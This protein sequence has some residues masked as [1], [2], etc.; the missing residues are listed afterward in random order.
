MACAVDA[1]EERVTF[2]YKFIRGVCPKS[3]G[4]NVARLAGLPE[5]VVLRARQMSTQFE[6][7]L[8]LAHG[9]GGAASCA[10][11]TREALAARDR[12][13]GYAHEE[14][15]AR[16][17]ADCADASALPRRDALLSLQAR[18]AAELSELGAL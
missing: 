7:R 12:A 4:N 6:R 1:K 17:L 14:A 16:A 18:V 15:L 9:R 10:L 2:L 8:E 11:D 13:D 5:R 3:Y